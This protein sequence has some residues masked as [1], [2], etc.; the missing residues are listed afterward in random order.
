MRLFERQSHAYKKERSIL[1]MQK[2]SVLIEFDKKFSVPLNLETSELSDCVSLVIYSKLQGIAYLS[3][4]FLSELNETKF[5][6]YK[7][8]INTIIEQYQL[9]AD[10]TFVALVGAQDRTLSAVQ[11]IEDYLKEKF[12]NICKVVGGASNLETCV[13]LAKDALHIVRIP[14][15]R[16]RRKVSYERVNIPPSSMSK[17]NAVSKVAYFVE[18]VLMPRLVREGS[19]FEKLNQVLTNVNNHDE[20]G[21]VFNNSLEERT[22]ITGSYPIGTAYLLG[23]TASN[24]VKCFDLKEGI[25]SDV[26]SATFNCAV[27]K[28]NLF[29]SLKNVM[30][31]KQVVESSFSY[32]EI[33][34]FRFPRILQLMVEERLPLSQLKEMTSFFLRVFLEIDEIVF[35]PDGSI[36]EESYGALK[37]IDDKIQDLLCKIYDLLAWQVITPDELYKLNVKEIEALYIKNLYRKKQI[38]VDSCEDKDE[39]ES[40]LSSPRRHVSC[41]IA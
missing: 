10:N 37:K 36:Y 26:S 28:P 30:G 1:V 16:A 35:P 18:G 22:I 14:H 27:M 20:L 3:H 32:A 2:E 15:L 11:F 8:S 9:N 31:L 24:L 29:I 7:D 25:E 39:A 41:C 21:A 6:Q 23:A 12:T 33:N 40:P 34:C 13:E 5:R 38:S 4:I 19:D 17:S